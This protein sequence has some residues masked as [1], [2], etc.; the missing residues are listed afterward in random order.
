MLV[1]DALLMAR[2]CI[3]I[4]PND[5]PTDP[6]LTPLRTRP[7]DIVEIR[8]DGHVW[9]LNNQDNLGPASVCGQYRFVD[10]PGQE[11]NWT[12]LKESVLYGEVFPEFI[13]REQEM[14]RRRRV[15]LD[16]AALSSGP[17][18]TRTSATRN[19]IE[20]ITVTRT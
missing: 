15:C 7:G 16:P 5:H 3:R 13:G 17:W 12:Y 19:Q 9:R 18:R 6:S 14:Y 20:A 11:S 10:V 4:A 8:E 2:L 1:E